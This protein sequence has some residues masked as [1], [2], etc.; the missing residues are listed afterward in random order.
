[1][2]GAH[3]KRSQPELQAVK[4]RSVISGEVCYVQEI[5]DI[6]EMRKYVIDQLPQVFAA[7]EPDVVGDL[8]L[9]I[10]VE[11]TDLVK[12][13]PDN[14]PGN[15]SSPNEVRLTRVTPDVKNEI[16]RVFSLATYVRG[17]GY[18]SLGLLF[19]WDPSIFEE[20]GA[21]RKLVALV[22]GGLIM[23]FGLALLILVYQKRL[24]DLGTLHLYEAVAETVVMVLARNSGFKIDFLITV[25]IAVVKGILGWWVINNHE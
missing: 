2:A 21:A 11:P 20:F 15:I 13:E 4:M 1:M 16:L 18:V 7:E 24:R 6:Q 10:K 17:F 8:K 25:P 3:T 14:M 5:R 23:G 22:I 12:K 19:L 9:A